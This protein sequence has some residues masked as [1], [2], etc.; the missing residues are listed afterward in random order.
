MVAVK[1]WAMTDDTMLDLRK[2]FGRLVSA[3]RRQQQMTQDQLA[4]CADLSVDMIS[5]I[6]AGKSGASFATI[7]KL[8]TALKVDPAEFFSA[9]SALT[10]PRITKI[11]TRLARL[12]DDDLKWL[13]GVLEAV[14]KHR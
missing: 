7:D 13:D 2:R 10:R 6:E 5:R 8:A 1:S 12:T 3:H 14:L 9:K 4:E 11:V